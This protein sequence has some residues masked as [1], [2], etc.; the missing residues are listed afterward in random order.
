MC[1][2]NKATTQLSFKTVRMP[3]GP[4]LTF[5]VHQFTL[6]KDVISSSKKQFIDEDIFK[7]SPLVIMNNFAGDGKHLKLMAHT[8]QNMFPAINIQTVNLSTIRRCVLFNY[9]PVSKLIQFRH[10]SIV[11]LPVGISRGVK[12]V[13]LRK[14]P[15]LSKCEDISDYFNGYASESEFEDDE[16]SHV[17]LPQTLKSKGNLENNKSAVRL[18]EIGPR[19]TFE[20]AKIEEGLFTGEVLYHETIV[21]SEEEIEKIRKMVEKKKKLKK[22]RKKKQEE[23][24]LKKKN[25][26]QKNKKGKGKTEVKKQEIPHEEVESDDD[27]AYYKEEIGEEPDEE[28]FKKI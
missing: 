20:L 11:V 4:T 27:A 21:K 24:V 23:N 22:Q 3:R 7:T 17:I 14:I 18:Y 26:T 19:L 25:D 8:F 10:Y 15:N 2:F 1:V 9:D 13:V 6:A 5:K 12:K 28:I 16:A